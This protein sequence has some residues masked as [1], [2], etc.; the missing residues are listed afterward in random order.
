MRRTSTAGE[1]EGAQSAISVVICSAACFRRAFE[2]AGVGRDDVVQVG[3]AL[4]CK[5]IER[6]RGLGS[7][8]Q[9]ILGGVEAQVED[10]DRW[11]V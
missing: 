8:L 4:M 11:V 3:M 2:L 1:D 7:S 6:C 10:A 5:R 9:V